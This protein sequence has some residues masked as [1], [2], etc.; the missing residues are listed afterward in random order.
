MVGLGVGARDA[1]AAFSCDTGSLAD[2][3]TCTVTANKTLGNGENITGPNATLILSNN[4]Q[5]IGYTGSPATISVQNLTINSGSYINFNRKGYLGGI[6]SS[7]DGFW[8]WR[9]R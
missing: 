1:K 7:V 2:G 6:N 9:R 3:D 5:I 4:A 8:S